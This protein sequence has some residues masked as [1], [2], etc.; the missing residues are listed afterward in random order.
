MKNR[1]KLA[2]V[3]LFG[4]FGLMMF[5]GS[6]DR[7]I[8]GPTDFVPTPTPTPNG[9]TAVNTQPVMNANVA[10][11]TTAPSNANTAPKANTSASPMPT[12]SSKTMHEKFVLGQNSLDAD[13]GAVPFNHKSHAFMNYSPD[14]KS[15]VGC[16]ECH[17]TDQPKSALKLP[18]VTSE[19]G[20]ILTLDSWNA[21]AQKVNECSFCHFQAENVPDGKTMPTA[22]YVE[23]GET[24]TKELN[25]KLAYHINCNV[26]HDKAAAARP[27]LKSKPGF[28]T[29]TGCASCHSG[30]N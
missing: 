23:D 1:V 20:E 13:Y 28:A 5:L 16:V 24:V 21:S 11:N 17:H 15:V 22:D 27:S 2:A 9:N 18:L 8:A 12:A 3:A 19:R 26:C 6:V 25:N 4:L 7:S 30:G 10:A 29:S 14:G